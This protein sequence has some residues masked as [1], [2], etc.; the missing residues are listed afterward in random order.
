MSDTQPV[1]CSAQRRNALHLGD[2]ISGE[3]QLYCGYTPPRWTPRAYL[4][5]TALSRGF[6]AVRRRLRRT[7][8]QPDPG[9][10]ASVPIAAHESQRA[11][12]E[13]RAA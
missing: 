3:P 5:L 13:R 1:S 6:A 12:P 2:V 4:L 11:Q 10:P 9:A 7:E 8:A